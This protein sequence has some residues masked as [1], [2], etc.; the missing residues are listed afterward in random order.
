MRKVICGLNLRKIILVSIL[1]GTSFGTINIMAD[2]MEIGI[3]KC[4]DGAVPDCSANGCRKSSNQPDA[5]WVCGYSGVNC[6][7]LEPVMNYEP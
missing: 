1:L 3:W 7:P 4:P 6:P 5:F 2:E